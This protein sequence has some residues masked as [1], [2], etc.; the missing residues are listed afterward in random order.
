RAAVELDDGLSEAHG[1]L[2]H[3][4]HNYDWDWDTAELEYRRAIVLN[5]NNA[6]AHHNYA[7]LLAQVGRFGEARREIARAMALD[8]LSATSVVAAGVFEYYAGRYDA[9][10]EL[11]RRA[12]RLDTT[13][14][15]AWR[16]SAAVL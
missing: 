12:A 2:A 11:E 8:P 3:I 7:H 9:A 4:L 1:A 15:V 10:L 16:L 5:P 14:A 13:S 6:I